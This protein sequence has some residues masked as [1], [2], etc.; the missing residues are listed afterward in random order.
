VN[1]EEQ[2]AAFHSFLAR[3]AFTQRLADDDNNNT[4]KSEIEPQNE[5]V[6]R[7]EVSSPRMQ[8]KASDAVIV[9]RGRKVEESIALFK[10]LKKYLFEFV[11]FLACTAEPGDFEVEV[12]V[13]EIERRVSLILN[14]LNTRYVPFRLFFF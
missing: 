8:T 5:K 10:A 1:V 14:G 6:A 11:S 12:L 3:H 9:N 2:H 13:T 7:E 4:N